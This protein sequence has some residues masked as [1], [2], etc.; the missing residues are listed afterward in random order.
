MKLPP[1]PCAVLLVYIYIYYVC[2]M[3]VI[4][5]IYVLYMYYICIIYIYILLGNEKRKCVENIL[6]QAV[7][8][9]G[10]PPAGHGMKLSHHQPF[11]FCGRTWHSYWNVPLGMYPW[12]SF[13]K[14]DVSAAMLHGIWNCSKTRSTCRVDGWGL[15]ELQRLFDELDHVHEWVCLMY[16][17]VFVWNMCVSL[18]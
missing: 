8:V 3:Y 9:I 5:I 11:L 18:S 16:R 17:I 4:C 10:F 7:N 1:P 6:G 12:I 15:P 13:K 2:N 14:M